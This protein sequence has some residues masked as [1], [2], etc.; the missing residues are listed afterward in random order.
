MSPTDEGVELFE[1]DFG[2]A[3]F[4]DLPSGYGVGTSYLDIA[5]GLVYKLK[6]GDHYVYYR[7]GQYD[8]VF[9]YGSDLSYDSNRFY[10]TNLVYT[11]YRLS[12]VSGQ[13]PIYS[14][15]NIANFDLNRGSNLVYSD[16]GD[17]PSLVDMEVKYVDQAI[18][19]CLCS[20]V[21]HHLFD[22]VWEWCSVRLHHRSH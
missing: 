9:V 3:P 16:L 7:N 13:S 22:S 12:S 4:A 10:G 19:L 20:F 17:F 6:Y 21:L 5:R 15:T 8:Y 1:E 11:T 18:L 14:V 2:I